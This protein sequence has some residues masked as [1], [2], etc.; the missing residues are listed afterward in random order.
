MSADK[1]RKYK[2]ALI[3]YGTIIQTS[4]ICRLNAKYEDLLVC[5]CVVNVPTSSINDFKEVILRKVLVDF[6]L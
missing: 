1:S 3:D 5:I 4:N 2:C 6:E